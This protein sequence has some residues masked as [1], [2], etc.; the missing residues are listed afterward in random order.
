MLDSGA[1]SNFVPEHCWDM[2]RFSRFSHVP[3]QHK[4][5]TYTDVTCV[6]YYHVYT[7]TYTLYTYIIYMYKYIHLR[8]VGICVV[9]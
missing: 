6:T 3:R 2:Y 7:Y 5:V 8:S 9:F 4:H 1:S